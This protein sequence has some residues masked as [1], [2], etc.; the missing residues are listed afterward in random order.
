M[1][2]GILT[3]ALSRGRSQR[4][5]AIT[6]LFATMV[7]LTAIAIGA[8]SASAAFTATG[9]S[10]TPSTFQAGG[11]PAITLSASADPVAGDLNGDDLSSLNVELPAGLLVNP[12]SVA[13][14]CPT[15]NFNAD[16]CAAATQVGTISVSYRVAGK[17]NTSTGAVYSITPDSN[18]VINFGFIVRP[19]SSFQKFLFKSGA[20]TGLTTVRQGLDNDYGL[21]IQI[22]SIPKTIKSTLGIST[23][24]TV[25]NIAIT[26]NPRS[27]STQTGNYFTFNPT[28]C[29]AANSRATFTSYAGVSKQLAAGFVPTGCDQLKMDATYDVVNSNTNAGQATG[30]SATVRMPVADAPIQQT[31]ISDITAKLPNGTTINLSTLNALALCGDAQLIADA[32]PAESRMGTATVSVPFLPAPMT[33][34]IYLT[35]RDGV[36]FAY[37]LRGA[38]G[39]KA[40]LRGSAQPASGGLEATFQS[41]PQ[42]PWSSANLNFTSLIINNPANSCPY[43][44]S[45]AYITGYSASQLI[46]GTMYNQTNCPPPDTTIDQKP[47]SPTTTKSPIFSFTATPA[48]GATF[49]CKIDTGDYLPCTSPYTVPTA[50]ADGS[51]MFVARAFGPGG[52]GD[53]TPA[54]YRFTVDTVPPTLSV[55][56]PAPGATLTA[57]DFTLNFTAE[58]GST[59]YCRLDSGGLL[60]CSSP[61]NYTNVADGAHK[62]RVYAI[63]AAGNMIWIDRSFT[64]AAVSPPVVS[65]TSPVE[66]EQLA[67]NRLIPRFTVVPAAG[68]TITSVY[69]TAQFWYPEQYEA[70]FWEGPCVDGQRI[71]GGMDETPLR[72]TVEATDSNGNVGSSSVAFTSGVAP[73]DSPTVAESDLVSNLTITDRTPTFK[74]DQPE[75]NWPDQQFECAF[76]VKGTTPD[77]KPCGS[78]GN[79]PPFAVTTPLADGKYTLSTRT[80][81]GVIYSEPS[82]MTFTVGSWSAV[83]TATTTTQQAGAHPDLDV[84]ITPTGAGQLHAVDM[85]LPKGLIGSLKSFPKCPEANVPTGSCP[86]AT[87]VGAVDVKYTVHGGINLQRTPGD[88]YFTGPQVPGD[89]AG[90]VINVFGPAGYS[91]VIIPLRIQL[92][93]N[94]Q[95]MRVF[96]DTIPT[97]VG[98]GADSPGEFIKYWLIDFKMHIEGSKGSAFPLLT[99]PSNC[100]ADKFT[101]S[102]G[103]TEG[104]ATAPA[105]IPYKATDCAALPFAPT[106]SQ[107]FTDPVAG[108]LTG[109]V[110]DIDLPAGSA[111][112]K[113]VRVR[114][115]A[116]IGA[117]L[118]SFGDDRDQCP[119]DAA[120]LAT[121]I[122]DPSGCPPQSV[123]GTMSVDTPLLPLPL[124][125][126]VYL[127][128]HTPLQWLGVVLEG[129]GAR[130]NLVGASAL[131]PADP[132]CIDEEQPSGVCQ[133]LI[134]VSFTNI[135]DLPLT[136]IRLTLHAA[137]RTS[138]TGANLPGDILVVAPPTH[139]TC[140][141]ADVANSTFIPY[142]GAPTVNA[143][144]SIFFSGCTPK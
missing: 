46:Y 16:T 131:P 54:T 19:T 25:S 79:L 52:L 69:C 106:I 39:T 33:G 102:F 34:E 22:P 68:A 71:F 98:K 62:I 112:M 36:Q 50:L 111:A 75:P 99:N 64:I 21:N 100:A 73:P 123:V 37:I 95:N 118:D 48:S 15:A 127:I 116:V 85:T 6:T 32:C 113:T 122:F 49:K 72:L 58:T 55:Q 66:G 53:L 94:S 70:V 65:I 1:S 139:K 126:K 121:S 67:T 74:L 61:F 143:A 130:V 109:V 38:R 142:S 110:A 29:T 27:G 134:S 115:P 28:R 60:P 132:T 141:G 7:A 91:D 88:V 87:K 17:I 83:Y 51:H 31:H 140:I 138:V 117:N 41:L 114:E 86:A 20:A 125:G 24:I 57:R 93:N 104:T 26:L 12:Q 59:N 18:S 80:V 135:P 3:G 45:W 13:T 9:W 77:W 10:L 14:P 2:Y 136:H 56:S 5:R 42:V 30:I 92:L 89:T 4:I 11:H 137:D 47:V 90:L 81:S 105:T 84:D 35:S 107:T 44:T 103:D 23:S 8:G 133:S 78:Q 108:H 129:Q 124:T 40:T 76:G 43:A 128:K 119:V 144:Q 63:D 82:L 101:A 96:S 120:P 97:D